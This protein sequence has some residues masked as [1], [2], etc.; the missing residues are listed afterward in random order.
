MG[1]CV[2]G[3]IFQAKLDNLLGDT[4]VI[5]SYINDILIFR[6]YLFRNNIEHLRMIFGILRTAGLKLNI[7]S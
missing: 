3:D 1:M 4:E 7:P 2:S 6:K 5:K